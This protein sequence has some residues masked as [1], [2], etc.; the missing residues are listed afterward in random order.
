MKKTLSNIITILVCILII[1]F[2]IIKGIISLSDKKNH[3]TEKIYVASEIL[4]I[5]HSINGLIPT[6]KDYYY[7]G[8]CDDGKT[9][10]I[11]SGPKNWVKKNFDTNG[12]ANE[13]EGVK[14][15]GHAKRISDY[16]VR[17]EIVNNLQQLDNID[18]ILGADVCLDVSYKSNAVK[19]ILAGV[20]VLISSVVFFLSVKARLFA[21]NK[22]ILLINAVLL[23]IG[24]VLM[25]NTLH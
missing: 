14:I 10:Y 6:G 16:E 23:L 4:E 18:F 25:I 13:D 1:F 2:P 12:I 3:H 24:L 22:T 17:N 21:G 15:K 11:I 9:G 7:I 19:G 8:V 20:I 5:E